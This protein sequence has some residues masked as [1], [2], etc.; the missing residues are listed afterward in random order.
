[1]Y[2]C[3]LSLSFSLFLSLSLT[4]THTDTQTHTNPHLPPPPTQTQ[5]HTHT[6]THTHNAPT[7]RAPQHHRRREQTHE[8][9]PAEKGAAAGEHAAP[10]AHHAMQ[11]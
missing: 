9:A 11:D 7:R 4:Q 8:L 3:I 2:A 10:R 5:T 6:H 1:M